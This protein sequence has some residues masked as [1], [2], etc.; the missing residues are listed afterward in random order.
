VRVRDA[1]SHGQRARQAQ[2]LVLVRGH[3]ARA[4]DA[5]AFARVRSRARVRDARGSADDD[6]RERSFG[7]RARVETTSRDE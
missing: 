7:A 5:R 1:I 2:R 6:V 3:R 4:R